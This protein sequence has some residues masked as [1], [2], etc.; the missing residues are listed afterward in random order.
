MMAGIKELKYLSIIHNSALHLQNVIED[1]LDLS[2]IENKQFEINL[3]YF[4]IRD[5]VEEVVQIM[6]F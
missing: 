2:R 4:N 1:A 5:S 6:E 3:E